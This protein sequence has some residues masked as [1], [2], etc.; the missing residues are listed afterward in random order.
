VQGKHADGRGPAAAAAG[1]T[2]PRHHHQ[3]D[4][5]PGVVEQQPYG[6]NSALVRRF[7]QRFAA[8]RPAEWAEAAA[9]F[10]RM[11]GSRTF[12][13][14]DRALAAAIEGAGRDDA[15]DAVLG[16]LAQLARRQ[17]DPSA[18]SEA[19]AAPALDPAAEAAL[20]ALL[21]LIVRDVLPASAF[22]ALYAPF[23]SLIPLA[24]LEA[25]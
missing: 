19:D 23:A 9:A 18:A 22:S 4:E 8:L 2:E 7:L 16:P 20:A 24:S 15:R 21:A 1:G 14:A 10:D 13:A 3:P 6:P 11:Q 17:A 25:A 5:D 12:V